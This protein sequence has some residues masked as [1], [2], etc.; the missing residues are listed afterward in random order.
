MSREDWMACV[1]GMPF[2]LYVGMQQGLCPRCGRLNGIE[3][4]WMNIK[5]L[6]E[7]RALSPPNPDLRHMSS[8]G[9]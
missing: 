7:L 1:C 2:Y 6:H 5:E 9:V 8:E 3:R 4:R